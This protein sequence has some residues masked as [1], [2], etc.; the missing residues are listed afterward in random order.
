MTFVVDWAL[1]NN[2]LSIYQCQHRTDMTFAVDWALNN[3]Y[4]SIYLPVP[5]DTKEKEE[6]AATSPPS[7]ETGPPTASGWGHILAVF[8]VPELNVEQYVEEALRCGSY[9]L[10]YALLLHRRPLCQSVPE[11]ARLV[12]E[13]LDWTARAT[14][15]SVTVSTFYTIFLKL[16]GKSLCSTVSRAA[17]ASV[18]HSLSIAIF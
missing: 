7:P 6:E 10:L 3:N 5:T 17:P 11:E 9:L 12:E 8:Q 14:P 16:I 18:I 4:L 2:Y 15:T 1:N 13:V